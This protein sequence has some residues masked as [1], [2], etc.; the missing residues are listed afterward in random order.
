VLR[1]GGKVGYDATWVE[2]LQNMLRRNISQSFEMVCL[3]DVDVPCRRVEL[4]PAGPGYWSKLQL[5][6]PGLFAGPVL[7]FDLDTVICGN[8]DT[9]I[10]QLISQS[11]FVMWH[12]DW[13]NISSSAIMYWNGDYSFVYDRYCRQP[14]Y[15]HER[16]S[17]AN[18]DGQRLV[19]DQAVIASLVPHVFVNQFVPKS[20]IH[21]VTK[22]DS[23]FN[24]DQCKILIFRK[25]NNKPNTQLEHPLVKEHWH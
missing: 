12:D 2:R 13:Y 19:G 10:D 7:Y 1:S 5:F 4:E 9:L 25:P 17:T 15:Y 6:R 21:V 24:L 3:S 11:E 14:E 20:C 16:Y 23:R 8:L 18:Q 22:D